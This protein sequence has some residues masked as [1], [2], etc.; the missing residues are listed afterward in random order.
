MAFRSFEASV[1][2]AGRRAADPAPIAPPAELGPAE[3]LA[4][5]LGARDGISSLHSDGRLARWSRA[6]FGLGP[7][8]PLADPRLESLRR[9]AVR[10]RLQPG[11]AAGEI[12][13][14]RRA[15]YSDRQIA[16]IARKLGMPA[17]QI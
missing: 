6:L 10:L 12:E 7:R 9:L 2:D 4:V 17:V 1:M 14:A 13:A 15:G 11:R 5:A 3:S 8:R 16:A